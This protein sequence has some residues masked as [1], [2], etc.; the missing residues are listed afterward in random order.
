MHEKKRQI[1]SEMKKVIYHFLVGR[2]FH[3]MCRRIRDLY[4]RD[5]EFF[6]QSSVYYQKQ[7]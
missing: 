6:R 7:T 2:M 3:A 1:D 4:N 5:M